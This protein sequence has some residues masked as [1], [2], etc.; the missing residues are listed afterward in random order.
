MLINNSRIGISFSTC[1]DRD[2]VGHCW[3]RR[4]ANHLVLAEV[5]CDNYMGSI[6]FS[7]VAFIVS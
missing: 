3:K 1:D 7:I 2:Y 5:S 6:S 4:K